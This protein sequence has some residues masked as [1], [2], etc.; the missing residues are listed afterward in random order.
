MSEKYSI[1]AVAFKGYIGQVADA[2]HISDARVYSLTREHNH[3]TKLWRLLKPLAKLNPDRLRLV[4]SD[5]N[6]KVQKL[7]E[8]LEIAGDN[9]FLHKKVSE[10]ITAI[11]AKAP[12]GER[13]MQILEAIAELNKELEKCE[14][15][16]DC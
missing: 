9:A 3:Y 5:F 15:N 1:L 12:R 14:V 4:Q 7:T 6:A 8:G 2:L 16:D 10:A 13:K 11:L